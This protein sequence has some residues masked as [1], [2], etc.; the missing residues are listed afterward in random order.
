MATIDDLF[1]LVNVVAVAGWILLIMRPG[2]PRIMFVSSTAIAI[3]LAACYSALFPVQYMMGLPGGF[4][5]L[6]ELQSLLSSSRWILLAAW[7][8]YLA[9]D[10]LIGVWMAADAKSRKIPH[11]HIIIPLVAT[12][13]FGPFGWLLYMVYRKMVTPRITQQD[14]VQN[15][16]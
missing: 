2:S 3:F 6:S 12:F 5:S 13:F 16:K 4:S 11:R 7:I 1:S 8:H 10:L 15:W 9:F 14:E